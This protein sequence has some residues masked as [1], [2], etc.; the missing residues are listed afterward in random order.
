M[1]SRRKALVAAGL[2]SGSGAHF[3]RKRLRDRFMS[4]GRVILGQLGTTGRRD[5][6]SCKTNA[7]R[8]RVTLCVLRS[9][10]SCHTARRDGSNAIADMR[11]KRLS[12]SF[13]RS[14]R[15]ACAPDV[16]H[17]SVMLVSVTSN[18]SGDAHCCG[19]KYAA[20]QHQSPPRSELTFSENE[21]TIGMPSAAGRVFDDVGSPPCRSKRYAVG[22]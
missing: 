21:Q 12:A 15:A 5:R 17:C 9:A 10:V 1:S 6:G 2:R 14:R 11:F 4:L 22:A 13:S 7:P 3:S 16:V 20:R 19:R 8:T 18:E